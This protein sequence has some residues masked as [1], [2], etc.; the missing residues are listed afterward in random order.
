MSEFQSALPAIAKTT[1]LFFGLV[2][3]AESLGAF[4]SSRILAKYFFGLPHDQPSISPAWAPEK[5]PENVWIPVVGARA[6]GWALSVFCMAFDGQPRSM[7]MVMIC[8]AVIGIVDTAIISRNG[9]RRVAIAH[10][11]GSAILA[12]AGGYLAFASDLA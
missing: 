2:V 10:L 7:G 6:L 9:V 12:A 3:T 1:G 4:I 5:A 11:V 8:G